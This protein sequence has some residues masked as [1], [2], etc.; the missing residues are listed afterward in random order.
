MM[1]RCHK[2]LCN[3]LHVY[4]HFIAHL[5]THD[6]R[7]CMLNIVFDNK[8]PSFMSRYEDCGRTISF[9]MKEVLCSC[10]W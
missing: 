7:I 6:Y 3:M 5:Y 4:Y 1:H 9:D 2:H 10:V 8:H